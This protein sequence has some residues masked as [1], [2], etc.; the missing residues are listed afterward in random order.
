MPKAEPPDA[1]LSAQFCGIRDN[2]FGLVRAHFESPKV[3][4]RRQG[5]PYVISWQERWLGCWNYE[6]PELRIY[7]A[8]GAIFDI[9]N[10]IFFERPFF[11]LGDL[12]LEEQ[13]NH[14]EQL[15]EESP[16]SIS[17]HSVLLDNR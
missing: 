15:L 3:T 9:I 14:F 5:R 17:F 13:L 2:I 10:G 12:K 7:R 4:L 8:Q 11:V 1:E 16:E 6:S